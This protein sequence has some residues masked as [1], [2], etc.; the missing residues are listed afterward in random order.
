MNKLHF[1][2][3]LLL[4]LTARHAYGKVISKGMY[5]EYNYDVQFPNQFQCRYYIEQF[6]GFPWS[7]Q[8]FIACNALL[9]PVSLYLK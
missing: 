8:R 1:S 4:I 9:M 2:F 3:S 6:S 7:W 5:V